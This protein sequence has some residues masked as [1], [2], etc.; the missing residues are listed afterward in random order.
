MKNKSLALVF[1]CLLSSNIIANESGDINLSLTIADKVN[2]TEISGSLWDNPNM[3]LDFDN[4]T[5]KIIEK[6]IG[7]LKLKGI[8]LDSN[9]Y[10]SLTFRGVGDDPYAAPGDHFELRNNDNPNDIIPYR[11]SVYGSTTKSPTGTIPINQTSLLVNEQIVAEKNSDNNCIFDLTELKI[12]HSGNALF[13]K[14]GSY[15]DTLTYTLS[16]DVN[17]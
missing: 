12:T 5:G 14:S 15:S 1:M 8:N 4:T 6:N 9:T 16:F 13:D 2:E 17:H 11:L 3:E 7:T 10:C